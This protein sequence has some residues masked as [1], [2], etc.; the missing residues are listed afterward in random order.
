MRRDAKQR[1]LHDNDA[2]CNMVKHV[3]VDLNA[4]VGSLR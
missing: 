2:W 3:C 1:D 4:E